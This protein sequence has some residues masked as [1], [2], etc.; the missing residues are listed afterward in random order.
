MRASLPS[1]SLWDISPPRERLFF[2]C[3]FCLCLL[4]PR[5]AAFSFCTGFAVRNLASPFGWEVGPLGLG[6]GELACGVVWPLGFDAVYLHGSRW[7][8]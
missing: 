5:G 2:I 6:G 3:R 7:A 8:W 4:F 1:L